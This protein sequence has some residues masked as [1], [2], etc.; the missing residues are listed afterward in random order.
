MSA[1]SKSLSGVPKWDGKQTTAGMYISKLEALLEYHDSG[2]AIDRVAMAN[3]P[4]KSEYDALGTTDAGDIKKAMLYRQN[5]RACAIMV[6]GQ[7]SDHGLA[8]ITKTK[9]ADQPHGLAFEFIETMKRKNKPKD[10]SA[11]IEMEAE[12]HNVKFQGANDYYNDIVAVTSRYEVTKSD[13]D[14]IKIMSTKVQST[15]FADKILM[16]LDHTN[17]DDIETLCNDIAKI[18]RLARSTGKSNGNNGGKETNLASAEGG[19]TFRGICGNCNKRCGFKRKTCPLLKKANGG[20]GGGGGGNGK[21]CS[22]CGGKGHDKDSC[23]KLHPDKAPQWIKDK[24]KTTEAAGAGVEVMLS[25][26]DADETQ[27]FGDACP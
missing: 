18:Q 25:Q 14:L 16:H 8:I 2:D 20:S 26:V 3:C 27:D 23:W 13:T 15:V 11:E 12:L 1:D 7:T 21:V 4:T 24:M 10:T 22:H 9:T 17:S 6:L 19:G 5:K